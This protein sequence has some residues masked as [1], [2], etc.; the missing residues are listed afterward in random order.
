MEKNT[1]CAMG[2]ENQGSGWREAQRSL[3]LNIEHVRE[4]IDCGCE[5]PLQIEVVVIWQLQVQYQSRRLS[6]ARVVDRSNEMALW[7]EMA[8]YLRESSDWS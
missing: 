3:W 2:Y 7:I 4:E 6:E 5:M 8:S 1:P